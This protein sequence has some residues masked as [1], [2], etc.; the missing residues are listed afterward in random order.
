MNR[1]IK[2]RYRLLFLTVLSLL[3]ILPQKG[4]AQDDKQQL[5]MEEIVFGH[6]GDSYEWHVAT[7]GEN[8]ELSIPLPIIVY[9][10][11]TGW[12]MFLSS[13]LE[14]GQTYKG[15]KISEKG[16]GHQD[17]IVEKID[18]IWVRPTLDLSLTKMA[19]ALILNALLLAVIVLGV[20]R[21]YKKHDPKKISPGGFTGFMEMFIMMVHDDV[22]KDSVGENY[23]RFAPYLLTV[24][25]FIFLS[26]VLS[27]VPIFPAGVNVTGN[28]AITAVLALCTMLAVNLFASK[29]YWK[30]VFWPDVPILLKAPIPLIPLIEFMG[31]FTKPFA[32][33]IR[34]F[35]NMLAGHM[36]IIIFVCLIFIAN[37]MGAALQGG[38]SVIS[39][40]FTLFMNLLELLVAF[41]QA[42]VF[43]LLSAVFIGLAQD[44]KKK[45]AKN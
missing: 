27:L 5:D 45:K 40:L 4:V 1:S 37:S 22:I 17:K 41:I 18:G 16:T 31:I 6:M 24:F 3:F 8:L 34:L 7:L 42:Y 11:T 30:E 19:L 23:K 33:M 26:N 39:I 25:F 13:K 12:N 15:F 10:S 32:L 29:H 43:T 21:W 9:S 28:I 36:A 44:G 35:A 20:A 14:H 38:L 2:H